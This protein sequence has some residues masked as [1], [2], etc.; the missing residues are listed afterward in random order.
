MPR[1]HPTRPERVTSFVDRDVAQALADRARDEQRSISFIAAQIL[2][3]ALTTNE[4]GPAAASVTPRLVE[5]DDV[6][7][8]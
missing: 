2:R 3:R 1:Q 5:R 7:S 6:L 8:A 4:G